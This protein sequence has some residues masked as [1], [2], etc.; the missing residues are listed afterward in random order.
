MATILAIGAVSGPPT[1]PTVA[2]EWVT[3]EGW[4]LSALPLPADA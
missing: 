1:I 2:T 3:N 4:R